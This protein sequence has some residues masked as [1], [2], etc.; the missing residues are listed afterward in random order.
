MNSNDYLDKDKFDLD[1]LFNIT[2]DPDPEYTES[3]IGPD[4]D[5]FSESS[6]ISQKMCTKILLSQSLMINNKN[7][8]IMETTKFTKTELNAITNRLNAI[9]AHGSE[10]LSLKDI[11]NFYQ[12]KNCMAGICILASFGSTAYMDNDEK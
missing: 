6:E 10:E 12:C 8:R 2:D 3:L 1:E 11:V 7:N 5:D 9:H 4:D